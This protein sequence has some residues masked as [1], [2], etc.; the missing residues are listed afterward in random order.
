MSTKMQ[1]TQKP[2]GQ[3]AQSNTN[4][5]WGIVSL[6]GMFAACTFG[7]NLVITAIAVAMFAFGA[8]KGGY[9]EDVKSRVSNKSQLT[10]TERR[11][12]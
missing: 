7:G 12:A 2:A 6:I 3:T 9:M 5:A 1:N 8:Y 11:A 10:N 4:P